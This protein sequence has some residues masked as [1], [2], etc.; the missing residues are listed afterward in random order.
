MNNLRLIEFFERVVDAPE[1]TSRFRSFVLDLAVRGKLVPQDPKDEPASE[2]LKQIKEDQELSPQRRG[3]TIIE[4]N[5]ET[6][7]EPFELRKQ[8]RWIRF[9]RVHDLVRGVTYSSSDVS[10]I[11]SDGHL[12]V[13]R[14]N[15]IGKGLNFEELVFVRNSRISN[16]QRLR[17]GDYL[18]ALSSGSKN[19]VGKAAFVKEDYEAAFGGFCGVIRLYSTPI[20]PFVGVYLASRLYREAIAAGSRGIGI[21]NLKKETLSNLPFPL[22]P[23]AE[24]RRIVSKVD[25]LMALCDRLEA[26]LATVN[27]N[28]SRLLDALFAEALASSD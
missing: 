16:E 13:L 22:P 28:R 6:L 7:D 1:A 3:R 18:I 9:G 8:W 24:Q 11:A 27:L 25:E 14:A 5:D 20:T 12:P 17:A 26:R 2:L 21:N 19:L 10:D 23:L 4:L 15:N